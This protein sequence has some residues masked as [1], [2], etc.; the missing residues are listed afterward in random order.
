[1][2]YKKGYRLEQRVRKFLEER[3]FFVVRSAGSKS[4]VDLL[5]GDGHDLLAI[6]V[7]AGKDM[8]RKERLALIEAAEKLK[9][10]PIFAKREKYG[11]K[12]KFY[13]V[14]P[15]KC[16]INE[17]LIKVLGFVPKKPQQTS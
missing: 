1:M 6:Q 4:P 10:H 3:G 8:T 14:K 11:R 13:Y 12:I 17:T 15:D 5:A 9:A 2:S 16:V 7:K